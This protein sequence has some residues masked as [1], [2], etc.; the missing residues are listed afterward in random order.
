MLEY[1]I[2]PAEAG[3]RLDKLVAGLYPQYTR[4]AL[5]LLFDEGMVFVNGSPAKAAYKVKIEDNIEVDES[6]IKT[7]PP[8]ADLPIIFE[9]NDVIVID[10]PAGILTHSKG[11]LNL[12]PTVASFIKPKISGLDGNRSGIVHRLDRGTSG[13]IITAK[14]PSSLNWLQKQF[15]LR[16]VK[17][18]YQAIVEGTMDPKQAVIDAP[19][20]RN[21]RKP[22]TFKVL[23]DG[24]KAVTEYK[25]MREFKHDG[26]NYSEIEL[27][28][29]TGRT[30]QIR[31][32]LAYIGHPIVG[33]AVYGHEGRPILL[34][35]AALELTLPN[36]KREVFTA[37]PTTSFKDFLNG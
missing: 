11:A 21:S 7:E 34:H 37:P 4:S 12:E 18:T 26:K 27:K 36:K 32:H 30:H 24:R 1:K 33:D 23:S 22:Q 31:V 16:K 13:V 5:E 2:K 9:N 25:V 29:L 35:A 3:I 6:H 20:A 19:I 15:S 17:K 14:N 28:P 10:K 8:K